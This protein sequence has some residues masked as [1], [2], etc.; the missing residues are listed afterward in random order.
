M[1]SPHNGS[2]L[3]AL[4]TCS[5]THRVPSGPQGLSTVIFHFDDN[6]YLWRYFPITGAQIWRCSE[7]HTKEQQRLFNHP[8]ELI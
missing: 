2:S 5:L 3:L 8:K 6:S 1:A 4:P 7:M